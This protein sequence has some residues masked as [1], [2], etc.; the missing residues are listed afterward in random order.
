MSKRTQTILLVSLVF[1]ILV[2]VG[3]NLAFSRYGAFWKKGEKVGQAPATPTPQKSR[4]ELPAF[5]SPVEKKY[6]D[7]VFFTQLD[8]GQND[9]GFSLPEGASFYSGFEGTI[10]VT[11]QPPQQ[12]IFLHSEDRK[13]RLQ[14]IFSGNPQVTNMAKVS[15]GEPLGKVSKVPLPTREFNLIVRY[16]EGEKGVSLDQAFV[17]KLKQSP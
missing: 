17:E 4:F 6:L 12:F 13:K 16:F 5:S 2:F 9:L 11:G 3:L 15:L 1:L 8:F 10:E 14:Y 7:E